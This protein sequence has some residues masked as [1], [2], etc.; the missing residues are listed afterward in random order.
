MFATP[1]DIGTY[2]N[3]SQKWRALRALCVMACGS[4]VWTACST[5]DVTSPQQSGVVTPALPTQ[6]VAPTPL[7]VDRL[8]GADTL[9]PGAVIVIE[10]SGFATGPF[11]NV[12]TLGSAQASVIVATATRLEVRLPQASAFPCLATGEHQLSIASANRTVRRPV[13]VAVA[14]RVSLEP[15]QSL[16]ML[17]ATS[18]WCTELVVPSGEAARYTMAVINTSQNSAL[19]SGFQVR[20]ASQG[21]VAPAMGTMMSVAGGAFAA[22]GFDAA[23]STHAASARASNTELGASQDEDHAH[24]AHLERENQRA[25]LARPAAQAWREANEV[26]SSGG[27]L[28]MSRAPMMA[29]QV[30]QL[31]AMYASCSAATSI[32]ARVVYAGAHAVVLEDVRSPSAGSMDA[33][34]R[35][36]GEEFDRV[37]YPLLASQ[38]GNPVALSQVMGGDN[39]VSMLFTRYVNDSVPNTA[40]YV[41]ACNLYPRTTYANSNED[42]LFYARVPNVGETPAAWRRSMRSTVMHEAKH[43]AA[44]AERLARGVPFEEPW[45]EEAT[46]RIAEELYGRTFTPGPVESLSAPSSQ[47][48]INT[49]WAQSLH[50]EVYQC[51]DRPLVMWKHFPALHD[52]FQGVDS[53]SPLGAASGR[54]VSY[55]ASGWSLVRWAVDHYASNEG[56]FLRALVRGASGSGMTALAQRTGRP[57]EELLAEWSL[58]NAVDD[59]VGFTPFKSTLSFPSWNLPQMMSGLSALNSARYSANPLRIRNITGDSQVGVSQLRGFSA[60]YLEALVLRG[61]SQLVEL[62]GSSGGAVPASIRMAVVRVE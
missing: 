6:P 47:W 35:A 53:L 26:R 33:E 52:Y 31:N 19:L 38:I 37:Q 28:A 20:S 11:D 59:R 13:T 14:R 51:E 25:A 18:R 30:V 46:A 29:G 10:G 1:S 54:D 2:Q 61:S 56:E 16:N 49:G 3:V 60:S 24:A 39:R 43:L 41:T 48:R 57:V 5:S 55:Y 45:L 9:R 21:A 50:C 23:A 8:L 15:G 22:A 32:T 7:V 27:R 17:E 42:E 12:V 58:A 34:Y 4:I 36:I 44:F 40:G 62:R